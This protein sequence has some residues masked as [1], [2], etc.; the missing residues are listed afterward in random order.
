M[1]DFQQDFNE[2]IPSIGNRKTHS[3]PLFIRPQVQNSDL[4]E[5]MNKASYD[6]S[7]LLENEGMYNMATWRMYHRIQMARNQQSHWHVPHTDDHVLDEQASSVK[8]LENQYPS[9]I[10]DCLASYNRFD[11]DEDDN[12]HIFP[13][14]MD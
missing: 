2:P 5:P 3:I 4:Y 11:S 8:K 1:R 9:D 12:V 14:H 7:L 13:F 6:E 10:P